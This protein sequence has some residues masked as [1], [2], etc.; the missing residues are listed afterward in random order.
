MDH[1]SG[2]REHLLTR[3]DIAWFI[4]SGEKM[5]N[6]S[7]LRAFAS[8]PR[9][10][11]PASIASWVSLHSWHGVV[12]QQCLVLPVQW[13]SFLFVEEITPYL[14]ASYEAADRFQTPAVKDNPLLTYPAP[15]VCSHTANVVPAVLGGSFFFFFFLC[16]WQETR[17]WKVVWSWENCRNLAGDDFHLGNL[18]VPEGHLKWDLRR[19]GIRFSFQ[20][21]CLVIIVT[22]WYKLHSLALHLCRLNGYSWPSVLVNSDDKSQNAL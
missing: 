6:N 10:I 22:I 21:V 8:C 3:I 1:L 15:L 9:A 16:S 4:F 20:R 2:L 18:S 17:K 5:L 14:S 19:R 11:T 12:S 7:W 13:E